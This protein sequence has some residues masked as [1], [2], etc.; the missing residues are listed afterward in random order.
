VSLTASQNV[1]LPPGTLIV[2]TQ[3]ETH[4]P[5]RLKDWKRLRAKVTQM[6]KRR[7]E[8][9]AFA[10]AMVGIAI[11]AGLACVVWVPAFDSLDSGSRLSFA[12]VTPLF[13]FVAVGTAVM[14]SLAFWG[15]H[16]FADS[17]RASAADILADM[18]SIWESP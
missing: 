16:L 12:W 1:P 18:D 4:F 7:R 5:I 10:W 11:S 9:S 6:Q 17:E 15:S 3:E 2:T 13:I 14:A 8:F